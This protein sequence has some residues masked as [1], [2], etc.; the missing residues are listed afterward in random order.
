[1]LLEIDWGNKAR[2]YTQDLRAVWDYGGD[3]VL[4]AGAWGLYEDLEIHNR[5]HLTLNDTLDQRID[6]T[7]K[8]WAVYGHGDYYLTDAFWLEGGVRFHWDGKD[9]EIDSERATRT[10]RVGL[11]AGDDTQITRGWTGDLSINYSALRDVTFYLKYVR[12]FKAGQFNGAA[13]LTTDISAIDPVDPESTDSFEAGL[14]SY[15]WDR[16]LKLNAALFYTRYSD[17]QVFRLSTGRS[18]LPRPN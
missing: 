1:L 14:K 8:A 2:Q 9:F 6:Q 15:W 11:G 16:R 7:D 12:G 5:F 10:G 17:Q 4:E 13:L 18:S 3:V